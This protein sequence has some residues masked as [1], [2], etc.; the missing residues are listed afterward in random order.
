MQGVPTFYCTLCAA[1]GSWQWRKLLQ[2]CTTCP[3]SADEHRWLQLAE[4]GGQRLSLQRT[5]RQKRTLMTKSREQRPRKPYKRRNG[6][7]ASEGC[8]AANPLRN[9][10]AASGS[11]R[12][13]WASLDNGLCRMLPPALPPLATPTSSSPGQPGPCQVLQSSAAPAVLLS[14]FVDDPDGAD[15]ECPRCCATVLPMDLTCAQCGLDREPQC[16]E[17]LTG[18]TNVAGA[19]P[20]NLETEHQLIAVQAVADPAVASKLVANKVKKRN[21][22]PCLSQTGAENQNGC[23]GLSQDGDGMAIGQMATWW[24]GGTLVPPPYLM[25]SA[26]YEDVSYQAVRARN[27]ECRH[28]LG[29]SRSCPSLV[30]S[31]SAPGSSVGGSSSAGSNCAGLGSL[32]PSASRGPNGGLSGA[33]RLEA[34]RLRILAKEHA[35]MP[36]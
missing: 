23:E 18:A 4:E 32:V 11:D 19:A 29:S 34:L 14:A 13:R 21:P 27:A 20:T 24:H 9:M 22:K 35:G 5:A 1:R 17:I 12:N 33:Q 2:P 30:T 7:L 15:E 36:H 3:R 28:G 16:P 25:M 31:S 6:Q 8:L 26:S 10:N